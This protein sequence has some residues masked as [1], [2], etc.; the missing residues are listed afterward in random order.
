LVT[1]S[2]PRRSI[3]VNNT[4]AEGLAT[5]T[6]NAKRSKSMDFRFFW[7][8]DS[9]Q[10]S[11]YFIRHIKGKWNIS[12]FFTKPLPK[13]KFEQFSPYIVTEID[14]N[15]EQTRPKRATVTMGKTS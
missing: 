11:Q 4:V 10:K 5:D 13:D 15:M 9:I 7:L 3:L 2:E 14:P 8:R 6:I 1:P 12:N